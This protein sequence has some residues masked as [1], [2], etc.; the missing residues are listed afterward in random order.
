MQAKNS[1]QVKKKFEQ[2]LLAAALVVGVKLKKCKLVSDHIVVYTIQVNY[3]QQLFE[4][5]YHFNEI[6]RKNL[7]GKH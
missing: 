1:I 4:L 7:S 5:G 6:N 3:H 2:V